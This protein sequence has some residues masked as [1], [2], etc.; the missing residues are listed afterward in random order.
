MSPLGDWVCLNA[1]V[2]LGGDGGLY[3]D[4]SGYAAIFFRAQMPTPEGKEI[5]MRMDARGM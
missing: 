1:P 4:G 2:P 3:P 5:F